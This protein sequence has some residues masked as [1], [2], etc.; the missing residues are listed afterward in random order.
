VVGAVI[1]GS[2]RDTDE[3]RML[4]FPIISKSVSPR[5]SHSAYSNRFEPIEINS[6]IVCGGVVVNPGDL[7]VADEIGVTV[8]PGN[9]MAKVYE[10]AREQADKEEATRAEILKGKSV[11]ELLEKFGRL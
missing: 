10:L 2:A 4:D 8:V 1:D 5:A 9:A 6:T 7:I 3:A 11:K